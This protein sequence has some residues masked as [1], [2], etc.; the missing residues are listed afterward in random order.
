M[1]FLVY[2][3]STGKLEAVYN[4]S[5]VQDSATLL[6]TIYGETGSEAFSCIEWEGDFPVGQKM[7][8][9][10][11]EKDP[12]YVPPPVPVIEEPKVV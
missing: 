4:I 8:N 2:K 11:L 7:V 5:G 3:K 6:K 9:L 10:K 12:L 1:E